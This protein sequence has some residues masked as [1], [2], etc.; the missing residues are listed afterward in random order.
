MTMLL[1]SL[2]VAKVA[3]NDCRVS[4]R[5]R[6]GPLLLGKG[7][8]VSPATLKLPYGVKGRG[9]PVDPSRNNL[10]GYCETVEDT[11]KHR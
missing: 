6:S 8:A 3:Q 4:T 11:K 5:V 9:R 2:L 7:A 10:G 1:I